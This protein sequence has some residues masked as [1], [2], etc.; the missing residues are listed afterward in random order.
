MNKPNVRY[1][2]VKPR[3]INLEEYKLRSALESDYKT[4]YKENT[5]LVVNGK[6]KVIYI[7]LDSCGIDFTA[8]TKALN[9]IDYHTS[10][11]TAGLKT[12]SR[13]FGYQPRNTIRRDY[14][15]ATSLAH[16]FPKEHA[17]ICSYA[18]KIEEIYKLMD[19]DTYNKHKD[20][21]AKV[22]REWKINDPEDKGEEKSLAEDSSSIFTSG[23]VNKNNPLKY[24][25]DTGNFKNVYSCMLGFKNNVAGGYLACPE[26]DCA[27]EIKNNS[28]HIFDG[29]NIL[30]GV[31]PI[32]KLTA[33]A[34]RY[35]LVYYSLK[36]MWS[37]LP[38]G[39]ELERIRKRKTEREKRRLSYTDA[40]P[41]DL[42]ASEKDIEAETFSK[43]R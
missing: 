16:D 8:I 4:L 41:D 35:T 2:E 26:Y 24:H 7:D 43:I 36:A 18:Q 9:K 5:A 21:A 14:C 31:T 1:I 29:Q 3:G 13:V 22:L 23:I 10:E 39:A 40:L 42:G 20:E 34:F 38:F 15:T 19:I 6:V 12:T 32:K 27:F 33:D 17:I 11:R 30:H 25:F 28:L 37:C